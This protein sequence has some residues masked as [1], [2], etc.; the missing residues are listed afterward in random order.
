MKLELDEARHRGRTPAAS[1][2]T[3]RIATFASTVSILQT[4]R[5]PKGVSTDSHTVPVSKASEAP[6]KELIFNHIP[7]AYGVAEHEENVGPVAELEKIPWASQAKIKAKKMFLTIH[8]RWLL[9]K[10]LYPWLKFAKLKNNSVNNSPSYQITNR[11]SMGRKKVHEQGHLR[12]F[13]ARFSHRVL[14]GWWIFGRWPHLQL[15]RSLGSPR[16]PPEPPCFSD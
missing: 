6:V 7:N 5:A 15:R 2:W 13:R 11:E 9:L 16:T 14:A 4:V 3:P 12:R 1:E 8:R 10:F